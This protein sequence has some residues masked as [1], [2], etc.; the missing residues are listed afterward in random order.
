[1]LYH[2]LTDFLMWFLGRKAE[3]ETKNSIVT[4][5]L[6][7]HYETK[8]EPWHYCRCKET[9]AKIRGLMCPCEGLSVFIPD[10]MADWPPPIA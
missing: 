6:R 9:E 10:Q 1:M 5:T 7:Q 2:F 4:T 3:D 8:Y